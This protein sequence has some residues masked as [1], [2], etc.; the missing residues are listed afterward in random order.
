MKRVGSLFLL[1][2]SS[3]LAMA[4]AAQE[5]SN[6]AD[7]PPEWAGAHV[8]NPGMYSGLPGVTVDTNE[9]GKV[10]RVTID[11]T[12]STKLANGFVD[13]VKNPNRRSLAPSNCPTSPT[14]AAWCAVNDYFAN[15]ST[16][17][18]G[19]QPGPCPTYQDGKCEG[20]A[21]QMPQG[22]KE[23]V[24]D[25]P[26]LGPR[27]IQEMIHCE[28]SYCSSW[29]GKVNLYQ[30]YFGELYVNS[31]TLDYGTE[32]AITPSQNWPAGSCPEPYQSLNK[33]GAFPV[34]STNHLTMTFTLYGVK[35]TGH[36]YV[37]IRMLRTQKICTNLIPPGGRC[38]CS[39]TCIVIGEFGI[40]DMDN[41]EVKLTRGDQGN[42]VYFQSHINLYSN[43]RCDPT[44]NQ[45][46]ISGACIVEPGFYY[47]NPQITTNP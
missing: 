19:I 42:G 38:D 26:V 7:K 18:I 41:V 8:T 29:P 15:P 3:V 17:Y 10:R 22:F 24:L 1:W 46:G 35:F 9:D 11:S 27:Q 31:I 32:T 47:P 39:W 12:T 28:T 25:I 14:T 16:A 5:D 34:P 6:N 45:Y 33:C 4:A 13:V 36:L 21:C 30:L 20:W 23:T 44:P 40:S 2:G 43:Y 37:H